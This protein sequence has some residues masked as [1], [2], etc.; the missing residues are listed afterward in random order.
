M[1]LYIHF[2]IAIADLVR[3]ESRK[4]MVSDFDRSLGAENG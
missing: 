4:E 3:S 1:H 2:S